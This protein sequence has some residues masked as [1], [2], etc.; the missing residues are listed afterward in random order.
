MSSRLQLDVRNLSLGCAIWWMLTRW[1]KT[2]QFLH[3]KHS[4][5]LH[6]L[7]ALNPNVSL[8]EAI[9]DFF[10]SV[11]AHL[12]PFDTS[13]VDCLNMDYTAQFTIQPSEIEQRLARISLHKSPLTR[14]RWPT[15]LVPAWF[16]F[17]NMQALGSYIQCIDQRGL[18]SSYL[19]VSWVFTSA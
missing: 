10:V 4:D 17:H 18:F 7:E 19:E 13:S 11:S 8:A 5:P 3:H 2:K 12:P 15:K 9:N 1:R 14:S 16:C 6:N